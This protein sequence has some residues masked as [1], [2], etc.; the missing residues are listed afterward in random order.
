MAEGWKGKTRGA[1]GEG[2]WLSRSLRDSG[3]NEGLGGAPRF[4][5]APCVSVPSRLCK[6]PVIH[7]RE[8][9]AGGQA[10][11]TT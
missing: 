6:K 1:C 4:E 3:P 9:L 7:S 5:P 8:T 11:I 10:G 2:T